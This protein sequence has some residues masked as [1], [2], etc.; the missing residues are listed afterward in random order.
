MKRR[1]IRQQGYAL[2][3]AMA[4]GVVGLTITSVVMMRMMN[5]T[6]QITQRER[7]DQA[8]FMAESVAN[9]VVDKIADLTADPEL[10]GPDTPGIYTTATELM[11]MLHGTGNDFMDLSVNSTGDIIFS[12]PASLPNAY[13]EQKYDMSSNVAQTFFNS[14]STDANHS[15]NFWERFSADTASNN[16]SGDL[17]TL[18]ADS[19]TIEST[20]NTLHTNFYSIYHVKKGSQEADVRISII[21]LATNKEGTHDQKLHDP[22]TFSKHDDVFKIQITAFLPN[23]SNPTTQKTLDIIVNRP[24]HQ[25]EPVPF[26]DKAILTG[27]FLDMQNG[28]VTA[29]PCAAQSSPNCIDNTVDGDVHSNGNLEIKAPNGDVRGR[30]TATGELKAGSLIV[31]SEDY[32]PDNPDNRD[33][34]LNNNI[35][36]TIRNSTESKSGADEMPMPEIDTDVSQITQPCSTTGSPPR[37]KDC[38]INGLSLSGHDHYEFEGTVHIRGSFSLSGGNAKV[39]CKGS[40]PCRI[41]IDDKSTITGSPNYNYQSEQETLFVVKGESVSAPDPLPDP[42]P[43][44]GESMTTCAQIS[45]TPDTDSPHGSLWYIDNPACEATLSGNYAFF[46]AIISKGSFKNNGNASPAGIQYATNMSVGEYYSKPKPPKKE[47]LFPAVIS[48]KAKRAN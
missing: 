27:G 48:W 18:L 34:D 5:A 2:V 19:D 45:G 42:Y 44:P 26:P 38:Y 15:K 43:P 21:P 12:R 14:L 25:G 13:S 24:V 28:V 35:T 17:F 1:K 4:I 8:T 23:L 30:A 31:S 10:G 11:E 33:P 40:V 36:Q 16:G 47:D 39:G 46:G 32:D 20:L 37:L 7:E 22:A 6:S 3:T 41:V 9:H 29:G